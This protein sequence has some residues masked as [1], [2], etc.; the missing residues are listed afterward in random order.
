MVVDAVEQLT[1]SGSV[2]QGGQ[3]MSLSGGGA[4]ILSYDFSSQG[5]VTSLFARDSLD[6]RVRVE[7]TGEII[8]VHWRSTLTARLRGAP[9]R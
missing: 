6:L 9:P 3:T 1:R 2:S 8:P 7:A 4:R 5:F